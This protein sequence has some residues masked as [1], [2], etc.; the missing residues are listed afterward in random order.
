MQEYKNYEQIFVDAG[1]TDK[2]L[3]MIKSLKSNVT[4]LT[5]VAGGISKAID[6]IGNLL[7]LI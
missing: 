3:E 6:F 1:S 5:N 4:V 2:S 7:Y